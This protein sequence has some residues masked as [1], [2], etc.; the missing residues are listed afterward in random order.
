MASQQLWGVQNLPGEEDAILLFLVLPSTATRGGVH[1]DLDVSAVREVEILKMARILGDF[2]CE[3]EE[4]QGRLEV[5]A[6][7]RTGQERDSH[8]LAP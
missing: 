7:E 1:H 4:I 5:H 3:D 6:S 2:H 8:M